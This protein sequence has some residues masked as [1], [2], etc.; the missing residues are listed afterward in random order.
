MLVVDAGGLPTRGSA[1]TSSFNTSAGNYTVVTNRSLA[2]CAAIATR[3]S[4]NRAVPFDPA[5]VEITPGP[6]AN[7][8]GIQTR[9][10]LFFGGQPFNTA[11]HSALV[12]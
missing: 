10:L 2:S 4:T 6:A 7:A 3:G 5:T 1:L 8:V 11:F 9:G 12:C